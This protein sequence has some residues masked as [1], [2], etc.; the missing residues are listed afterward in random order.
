[1]TEVLL[2]KKISIERC[3]LQIRSYYKMDSNLPFDEDFFKQDAIAMNLNRACSRAIDQANHLISIHKLGFPNQT[4]ESFALLHRAGII[5]RE[6]MEGMQKMVSF[7]NVLVH[8]YQRLNLE[9]MVSVIENH[10]DDLIAF[11]NDLF[12]FDQRKN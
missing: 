11:A 6:R 10:L 5:S 2:N 4:R 3:V 1:M 7:R 9:I 8:E 12:E